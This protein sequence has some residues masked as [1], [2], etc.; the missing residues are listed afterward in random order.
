MIKQYYIKV[1]ISICQKKLLRNLRLENIWYN[2]TGSIPSSLKNCRCKIIFA[3][4]SSSLELLA[5]IDAW[6]QRTFPGSLKGLPTFLQKI[7]LM[8]SES[9]LVIKKKKSLIYCHYEG[10]FMHVWLQTDHFEP[11]FHIIS[12]KSWSRI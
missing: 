7:F 9:A 1:N 11:Y 5:L 10:V 12:Y 2:K 6:W 8:V 4:H 3:S